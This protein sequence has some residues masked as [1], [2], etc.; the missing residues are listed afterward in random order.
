MNAIEKEVIKGYDILVC[1]FNALCD[2]RVFRWGKAG[3]KTSVLADE[4]GQ[5]SQPETL[6]LFL[7]QA[8]RHVFIGDHLQ[9]PALINSGPIRSANLGMSLMEYVDNVQR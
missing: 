3:L 6:S 8:K 4:V 7:L 5:A 9:L 2:P 1:T